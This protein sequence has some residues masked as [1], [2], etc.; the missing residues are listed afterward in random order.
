MY[1]WMFNICFSLAVKA[2][3]LFFAFFQYSSMASTVCLACPKG[4]S[5]SSPEQDPQP[6]VVSSAYFMDTFWCTYVV[7]KQYNNTV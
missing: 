4:L 6:C 3:G 5:C 7:I 2:C 1:G